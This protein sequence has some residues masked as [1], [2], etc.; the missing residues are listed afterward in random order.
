MDAVHT[1]V[2]CIF[3]NATAGISSVA[4]A[5]NQ[6]MT[7]C[8]YQ[9]QINSLA[10]NH[11]RT[12]QFLDKNISQDRLA[13][14]FRCSEIFNGHFIA[15]LA[16]S[17]SVKEFWKSVKIW[18]SYCDKILCLPFVFGHS[19]CVPERHCATSECYDSV[20]KYLVYSY[21]AIDLCKS[22]VNDT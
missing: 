12:P 7:Q 1:H 11:L 14:C 9:T 15:H 2:P 20:S 16:R 8:W 3:Y 6:R 21:T 19:V 13:I 18:H 4:Q 17:L 22:Y 5:Q 10:V